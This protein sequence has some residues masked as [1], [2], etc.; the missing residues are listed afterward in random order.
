M[1]FSVISEKKGNSFS[2]FLYLAFSL[3]GFFVL[4]IFPEAAAASAKKAVYVCLETLLP[5][6]FPF[7]VFS[8]LAVS[9]GF[10]GVCK[11]LFSRLM[12]PVFRTSSATATP[13]VLGLLSGFPVGA[14]SSAQLYANGEISKS[15]CE[16]ALTFSNS[17]SAGFIVTAVGLGVFKSVAVGRRLYFTVLF[18]SFL[19]AFFTC[20]LFGGEPAVGEKTCKKNEKRL[21]IPE[22]LSAVVSAG[23]SILSV[24]AFVVFFSVVCGVISAVLPLTQS[25]SAAVAGFFEISSG[26]SA[27]LP[28]RSP[29]NLALA[30]A[31]LSWS[32]LSVHF[33]VLSQTSTVGI[34]PVPYLFSKLLAAVIAAA[35]S[36]AA[37][38]LFGI[39]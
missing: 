12:L 11:K 3:F 9:F 29:E 19:S 24:S 26:A 25:V 27:L 17:P 30:A 15:D 22:F 34:S 8:N 20:R 14:S 37:F 1:K 13:L 23:K 32:G 33:Q 6:L 4:L 39:S 36:F 5:S 28:V 16:K 7:F 21:F 10:S 18:S 31:L 38:F 2:A 35:V